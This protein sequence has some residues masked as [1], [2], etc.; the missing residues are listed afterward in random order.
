MYPFSALTKTG[1][2][3]SSPFILHLA[4]FRFLLS[5]AQQPHHASE[6]LYF[7]AGTTLLGRG[8]RGATAGP[9]VLFSVPFADLL[10]HV[11]YI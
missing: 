6:P 1:V 3:L 7:I 2:L 8:P 5:Y 11:C 4:F 10:T 9:G